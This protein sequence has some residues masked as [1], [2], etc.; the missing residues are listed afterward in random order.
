MPAWSH[1]GMTAGIRQQ[2]NRVYAEYLC[3]TH[4][5]H[6]VGD[7]EDLAN[8]YMNVPDHTEQSNCTCAACTEEQE[9]L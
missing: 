4:N 8:S 5:I 7:L 6:T 1:P 3:A 2:Q 9:H